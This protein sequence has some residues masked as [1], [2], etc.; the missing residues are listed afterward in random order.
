MF[1]AAYFSSLG[2]LPSR[3]TEARFQ[4]QYVGRRTLDSVPNGR[5]RRID[6]RIDAASVSVIGVFAPPLSKLYKQ[7]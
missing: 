3:V 7:Y 4:P 5:S 1:F 2:S 6:S